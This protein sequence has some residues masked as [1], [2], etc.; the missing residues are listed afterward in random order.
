MTM[1]FLFDLHNITINVSAKP[2]YSS[3]K[4]IQYTRLST[5][6]R[7]KPSQEPTRGRPARTS[8]RRPPSPRPGR[9]RTLLPSIPTRAFCALAK[10]ELATSLARANKAT[11]RREGVR[12]G[13]H[14]RSLGIPY[15]SGPRY[16]LYILPASFLHIISSGPINTSASH[17]CIPAKDS[18]ANQ[19]DAS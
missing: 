3:R 5:V 6:R 7:A 13:R 18:S 11:E 9:N 14:T 19:R 2:I 16:S 1:Y 10:M 8:E 15:L 12:G 17:H 4:S